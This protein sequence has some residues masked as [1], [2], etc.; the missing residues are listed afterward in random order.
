MTLRTVMPRTMPNCLTTCIPSICNVVVTIALS[1]IFFSPIFG[2]E[3]ANIQ[4][5]SNQLVI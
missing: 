1:I 2:K 3:I 5:E 4:K